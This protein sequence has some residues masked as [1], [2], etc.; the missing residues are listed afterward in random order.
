MASCFV[1]MWIWMCVCLQSRAISRR[2][3]V[4]VREAI[5][6]NTIE[7]SEKSFPLL[8]VEY[9]VLACLKFSCLEI[10]YLQTVC[11]SL[12]DPFLLPVCLCL[13]LSFCLF[14]CL[15]VYL[16][17][18]LCLSAFLFVFF[19]LPFSLPFPPPSLPL[20]HSLTLSLSLAIALSVSFLINFFVI[21]V[22]GAVSQGH[23]VNAGPKLLMRLC[24][25][26][27]SHLA[28]VQLSV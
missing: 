10:K 19:P 18:C 5:K 6:Y 23:L 13:F 4:E 11:Y 28:R 3:Q 1:R 16:F 27:G 24:L 14:V 17:T 12:V 20:S 15:S 25:C 26:P 8:Y 7:S 21:C 2:D 22:F 9:V